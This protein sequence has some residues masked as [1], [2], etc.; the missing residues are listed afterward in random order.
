M[1]QKTVQ[2][3]L[4]SAVSLLYPYVCPVCGRI[5]SVR[6]AG[7]ERTAQSS[8]QLSAERRNPYICPA[9]YARISFPK[10]PRCL[11]CSRPLEEEEEEL[12][13][14]CGK[15]KKH[16]D[17]GTSLMLHD[18][19]S[20]KILYDLKYY[21]KRDNA[22]MLAYEAVLREGQRVLSWKPDVVIPVPLH[23]KRQQA[24]GFNQARL[25]AEWF[26]AYLKELTEPRECG[27][28]YG[29]RGSVSLPVDPRYL[30]RAHRTKA[31]KELTGDQRRE[32]VRNAFSI[33]DDTDPFRYAGKSI[34]L[35]DDIYTSGATL[36]ECARVLKLH[37]AELVYCLT[38]G[39]G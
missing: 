31:Q 25:L 11:C 7:S 10:E 26:C 2:K 30:I 6:R 1:F 4:G 24:R 13:C 34:L 28:G 32:N 9:C 12:C 33:R 23:K 14:D 21:N 20:R 27:P 15:K 3:M 37:G 38:F 17:A 16:F 18:E 22:R 19:I 39:M 29:A 36:S 5:L 35:V 8:G